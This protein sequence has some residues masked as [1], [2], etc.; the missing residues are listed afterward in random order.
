M[1]IIRALVAAIHVG[2]TAAVTVLAALLAV[3]MSVPW[4]T[5]IV[6]VLAVFL[7]Q[8]SV[9]LSNDALDAPRDLQA[10]RWDK[11][12]AQ[13]VLPPGVAW[14]VAGGAALAS[15]ILSLLIHPLVGLW[16]GVFL[17]AGW[18]YNLGLKATLWSGVCY[19]LGFGALPVLVGYAS[20]SA[21]FPGWWVVFVAASLGLSAH[22]ANVLPDLAVDRE[23]GVRGLPQRIGRDGVPGALVGLTLAS[24]VALLVGAG[25]ESLPYTAPAA[26]IATGLS[27]V[28]AL[29][30]RMFQ[31]GALPFRLSMAAAL[32]MALALALG[33]VL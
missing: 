5:G 13:G 2:P 10:G 16:Q 17:L 3:A 19:A 14:S 9:G 23:Q 11:P 7:N 25:F 1:I 27:V 4:S 18:A 30:S 8:V 6:V 31:P 21:E 22:F 32:V 29:R 33:L 20:P 15:V 26:V 28:G 24:A 12:I